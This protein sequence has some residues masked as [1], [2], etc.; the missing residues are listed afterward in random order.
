MARG[1][2]LVFDKQQLY[3]QIQ[4][5]GGGES[6]TAYR[7]EIEAARLH[8]LQVGE[9]VNYDVDSDGRISRISRA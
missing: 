7:A 9:R 5:E 4:P 8:D 2:V 3:A 6:L 1:T